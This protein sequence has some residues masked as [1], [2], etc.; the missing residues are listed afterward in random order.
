MSDDKRPTGHL[1]ALVEAWL[2]TQDYPPSQAKIAKRAGISTSMLTALKYGEVLPRTREPLQG[3]ADA[4]GVRYERVLD[5]V[6][7][8]QGLLDPKGRNRHSA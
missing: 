7:M 6:L 3:L 5:A 4:I 1:W 2:R 8:D